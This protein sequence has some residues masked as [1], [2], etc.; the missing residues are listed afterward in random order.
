MELRTVAEFYLVE[1]KFII[2]F[3]FLRIGETGNP[4]YSSIVY[5]VY[6]FKSR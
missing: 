3:Y 4:V 2:C 6:R 5:I 1:T